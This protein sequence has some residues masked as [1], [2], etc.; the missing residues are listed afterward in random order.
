LTSRL[1]MRLLGFAGWWQAGGALTTVVERAPRYA[2]AVAGLADGGV[3]AR[4]A[5]RFF[6]C[7]MGVRGP[8][9]VIVLV[10]R[11]PVIVRR[12]RLLASRRIGTNHHSA[13]VAA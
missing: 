6:V 3:V 4:S 5:E 2:T 12:S 1:R 13:H 11:A 8:T 7:I 9:V 10:P